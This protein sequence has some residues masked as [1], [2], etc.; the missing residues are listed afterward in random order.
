MAVRPSPAPKKRRSTRPAPPS[1][2]SLLH[3]CTQHEIL[4]FL[5]ISTLWILALYWNSLSA[6]F[7]YD[8]LDQ[9][10]NNPS[11]ASWHTFAHRFLLAPVAFTTDLRGTGGLS[12]RPL[13]WIT[14]FL[15]RGLW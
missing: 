6:P 11:L 5:A 7:V 8:D 2:P 10:V 4:G 13:Y 3:W 14:L 9:I 1:K 15:D 12:Y